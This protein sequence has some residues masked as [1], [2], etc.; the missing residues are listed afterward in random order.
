MATADDE[1]AHAPRGVAALREGLREFGWEEE[2]FKFA[3][4][5]NR[6]AAAGLGLAMSPALLAG[7]DEVI[8]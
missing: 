8:D 5:V 4:T 3:F 6:K 1:P 2:P 7:P